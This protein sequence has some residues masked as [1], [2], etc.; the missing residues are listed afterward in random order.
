[1]R[2]WWSRPTAQKPQVADGQGEGPTRLGQELASENP[3][4]V[5]GAFPVLWSGVSLD[6]RAPQE[7]GLWN[8]R[9][10]EEASGSQLASVRGQGMPPGGVEA[11][12]QTGLEQTLNDQG[13]RRHLPS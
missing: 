3:A 5:S 8:D 11:L 9:N 2:Q 7:S 1:M 12:R 13:V 6:S 10:P 4:G